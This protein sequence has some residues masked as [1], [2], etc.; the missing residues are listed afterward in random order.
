MNGEG[1]GKDL[2]EKEE[3]NFRK[4]NGSRIL[5]A[6]CWMYCEINDL[7]L[8]TIDNYNIG[9]C[10]EVRKKDRLVHPGEIVAG[11]ATVQSQVLAEE[12]SCNMNGLQWATS[13]FFQNTSDL[14]RFL[15]ILSK[16]KEF[17]LRNLNSNWFWKN[18]ICQT[19]HQTGWALRPLW[20]S[21]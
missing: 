4:R 20:F 1:G 7:A 8:L 3:K 17:P 13:W 21:H 10:S 14:Q 16:R 9:K 6:Q 19:L 11:W 5:S 12:L 15:F 2:W 18:E